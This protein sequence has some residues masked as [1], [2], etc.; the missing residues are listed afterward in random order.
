[1]NGVSAQLNG[2]GGAYSLYM[3]Y[4]SPTQINAFVPLEVSP[5]L[6][7]NTCAVAV[8]TGNG[9]TSYTT[10]CQSLTPALFN[11]GTQHY[12]SA[13]HLDGTI[14]GVIPGTVPAQS[15]SIIT[16]WGTG[17]GQTTPLT[18]STSFNAGVGGGLLTAPVVILVNN[19]PATV[20]Y[21]G[22]V[23]VGLY[24]FNIQLPDGLANGDYPVAIQI[25]G[26]TTDQVMIPVR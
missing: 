1:L 3:Y 11:Y 17:F 19:T 22:L 16:L 5:S 24:Q 8:T 10:Q 15:G 25:S 21:A 4:V 6:F 26:T 13:T 20:L 7:G 14:V 12:A 23:G 9:T 2:V 18:N